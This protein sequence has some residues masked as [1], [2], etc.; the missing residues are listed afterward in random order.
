MNEN[1]DNTTESKRT[2]EKP[3]P[4]SAFIVYL[5]QTNEITIAIIIL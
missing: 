1:I 3:N 4:A 5:S 2:D